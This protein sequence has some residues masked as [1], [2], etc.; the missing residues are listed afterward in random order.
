ME[1]DDIEKT[2]RELRFLSKELLRRAGKPFKE[3]P[4]GEPPYC[5]FCGRGRNEYRAL[6]PGP[7]IYICD[8]CVAEC[9]KILTEMPPGTS[10][11]A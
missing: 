7:Q 4:T 9:Q 2:Q 5:S 8:I 11:N 3:P 10:D 6:I 1:D